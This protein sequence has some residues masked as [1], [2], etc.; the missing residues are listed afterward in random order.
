MHAHRVH[1]IDARQG[2]TR[3]CCGPSAEAS[4]RPAFVADEDAGA[5]PFGG[6]AFGVRRP[7]RFLA[8][9]L[10]LDDAQVAALA[11]ILDAV[12]IERAQAAV[13]ER[14]AHAAFADALAGEAFDE[15]RAGE[16]TRLRLDSAGRLQKAVGEAVGR[17][18]ALLQPEQR[19]RLAYL[20]RTGALR[21]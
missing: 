9:R 1:W 19:A 6:G 11:G 20:I 10:S 7:L 8:H 4:S 15:A 3:S 16:A 21:L 17:I 12:K 5:G 18:H 14:R 2:G 13:D